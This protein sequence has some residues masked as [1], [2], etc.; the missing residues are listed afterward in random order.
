MLFLVWNHKRKKKKE[1]SSCKYTTLGLGQVTSIFLW[2]PSKTIW[3]ASWQN[4]QNEC[5]LN[6]D[7]DQPGHPPSLIRVFAVRMK[8]PWV[9]S[10]LLSAASL[11]AWRNL[12]SL[13][14]HWVHSEDSD[15]TGHPTVKT[16]QTG[17]MPR[18]IWVFTGRTL[19]LLVLSWC[20]SFSHVQRKILWSQ[21]S[22]KP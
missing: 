10:Y 19:I 11:S 5:A 22:V 14:T 6:E 16:D 20:G 21:W 2:N 13:A 8:K 15:Q 1:R 7:S 18:L 4:Q 3:P 12:G 9:L 17:R